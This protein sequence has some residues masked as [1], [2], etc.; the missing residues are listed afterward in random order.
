[1]RYV[2]AF[3]VLGVLWAQNGSAVMGARVEA[4]DIELPQI[5]GKIV[6]D[7]D[8]AEPP[9]LHFAVRISGGRLPVRWEKAK[10]VEP[11]LHG[12]VFECNG[13]GKV[14]KD[15]EPLEDEKLSFSMFDNRV[16]NDRGFLYSYH[17]E[18]KATQKTFCFRFYLKRPDGSRVE[19]PLKKI[20]VRN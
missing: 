13:E 11:E 3:C 14:E 19:S 16:R 7:F 12:Q 20:E 9:S 6:G 4:F 8:Q 18:V 5:E 10:I 15:A 17:P 1:M 2:L